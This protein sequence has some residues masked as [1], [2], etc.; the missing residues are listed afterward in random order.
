MFFSLQTFLESKDLNG[1]VPLSEWQDEFLR[2]EVENDN[3]FPETAEW[4]HCKGTTNQF[5][6]YTCG[7]WVAF[8]TLSASAYRKAQDRE[9]FV[10]RERMSFHV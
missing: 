3:P 7:L 1:S 10:L 6:G 2:A 4:E 5:R 9:F 8:H